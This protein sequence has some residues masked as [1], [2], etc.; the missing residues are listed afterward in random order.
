V[1]IANLSYLV[2]DYD[3]A[4]CWFTEKL[5]FVLTEDARL[6]ETKRWVVVAPPDHENRGGAQ[7]L[8]AKAEGA[9]QAA[10]IGDQTGGRVF[11]F[12]HTD[13]FD[14]DHAAMIAKGVR[15]LEDPRA[16]PYGKVAVFEDLYGSRWDLI[17][18][19]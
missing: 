1:E 8:L 16:E 7:I 2:R 19:R 18:P 3:E 10:R 9:A 5:G 11:L 12:L 6:S 17:E 14:R 13:D 4:I 15:F